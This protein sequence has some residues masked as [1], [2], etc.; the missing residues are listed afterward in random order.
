MPGEYELG[1][2]GGVL[3]SNLYDSLF[4]SQGFSGYNDGYIGEGPIW[5]RAPGRS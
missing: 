1:D 4:S 3:G 5:A 2:L